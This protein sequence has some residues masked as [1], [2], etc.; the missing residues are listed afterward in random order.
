M[1]F[2]LAAAAKICSENS[3]H[4]A[5]RCVRDYTGFKAYA[6]CGTGAEN[7]VIERL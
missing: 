1:T 4:D 6:V 7:F 2:A 3:C 5:R